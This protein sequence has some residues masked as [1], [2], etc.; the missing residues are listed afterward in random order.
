MFFI[1]KSKYNI[2]LWNFT[3]E[4]GKN[5]KITEHT[6]VVCKWQNNKNITAFYRSETNNM[7]NR[8]LAV[9]NKHY[10][11]VNIIFR[12]N[13]RKKIIMVELIFC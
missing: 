12:Q 5:D 9:W 10:N 1:Q 6:W 2:S 7:M 13:Y 3:H 4:Q 11:F 8:M